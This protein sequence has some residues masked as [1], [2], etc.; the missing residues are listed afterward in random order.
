[1]VDD[2]LYLLLAASE[3][4][5]ESPTRFL[6]DALSFV[7]QE[8][9]QARQNPAVDYEKLSDDL[10]ISLLLERGGVA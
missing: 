7:R 1:M 6:T 4:V 5:G 2:D 3:D 10:E 9:V 8:L